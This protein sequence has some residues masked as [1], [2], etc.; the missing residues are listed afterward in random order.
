[1]L[2]SQMQLMQLAEI[3]VEKLQR[4][5]PTATNHIIKYDAKREEIQI[6]LQGTNISVVI[7]KKTMGE[8][9]DAW[10]SQLEQREATF[11]GKSI[12]QKKYGA[13]T[14]QQK[15]EYQ[16]KKMYSP[17]QYYKLIND[18][19]NAAI[20]DWLGSQSGKIEETKRTYE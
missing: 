20:S 19:I 11:F 9:V 15:Y 2:L 13:M 3:L 10:I 17:S 8:F 18:T 12:A 1:M 16:Y 5:I 7:S 14:I 4:E 6:D